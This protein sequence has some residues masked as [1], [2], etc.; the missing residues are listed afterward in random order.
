MAHRRR[1][2]SRQRNL[3]EDDGRRPYAS[4]NQNPS[5][6]PVVGIIAIVAIAG[7]GFAVYSA[8][9]KKPVGAGAGAG[10]NTDER[11]NPFA[12]MPDEDGPKRLSPGGKRIV[13]VDRSPTDL[14]DDPVWI[15]AATKAN[16]L[17]DKHGQAQA[18]LKAKD[19]ETY[20]ALG[21]EVKGGLETLFEDTYAWEENLRDTYT[22]EDIRVRKIM[23]ERDRWLEL[24]RRNYKGL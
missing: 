20:L 11:P 5:M 23:D 12:D 6:A 8:Q 17:I 13:Q 16:A 4:R 1:P 24:V 2:T 7:V 22:D 19:N 9:N 14:L 21:R 3:E 18:A 10:A 15:A